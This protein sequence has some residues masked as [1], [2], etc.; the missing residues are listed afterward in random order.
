M[1]FELNKDEDNKS[2]GSGFD[3]NKDDNSSGGSGFNLGKD[4]G[5]KNNGGNNKGLLIGGVAILLLVGIIFL[6]LP[7]DS[8]EDAKADGETQVAQQDN[9]ESDNGGDDVNNDDNNQGTTTS[10]GDTP[11]NSSSE[12]TNTTNT[13]PASTSSTTDVSEM[14]TA[15]QGTSVLQFEKASN[16]ANNSS[17]GDIDKIIEIL[18]QDESRKITI[19]GYASS[20]GSLST[21]QRLSKERAESLAS[22]LRGRGVA[23]S[24]ITTI[25]M[26]IQNP[27]ADNDTESGRRQNRRVTVSF[28]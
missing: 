22:I 13:T 26:G 25:G 4:N 23:S 14:M 2:K 21:N 5:G 19:R 20:E 3:L 11:S 6:F 28:N 18:N 7:D 8:S 15:L 1:G 9:P 27:V 10:N 12:S 17:N 16:A 24:R